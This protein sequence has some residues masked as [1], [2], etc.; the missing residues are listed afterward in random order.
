MRK[1]LSVLVA[2]CILVFAMVGRAPA[3]IVDFSN[4]SG[5]N[6]TFAGSGDTFTFSPESVGYDFEI[7]SPGTAKGLYGNIDGTFKIGTITSTV[8]NQKLFQE[9]PVTTLSGGSFSVS[10]GA[11]SLTGALTWVSIYTYVTTGGINADG[12]VNL[13]GISYT[14]TNADLLQLKNA[15]SAT[16]VVTFQFSPAKSLMQL[17]EDGKTFSTSYS[18]SVSAVPIPAGI[19]FFAPGLL[20]LIGLRRRIPGLRC[21]G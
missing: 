6:V 16:S 12:T 15:G 2:G 1:S 13:T 20:G 7:T 5:A 21:H 10:D 14:G 4:L 3:T 11:S 9:A 17:T 18:G 19:W 8:V